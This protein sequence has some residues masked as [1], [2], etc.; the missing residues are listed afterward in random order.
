MYHV[1]QVAALVGGI[2]RTILVMRRAAQDG[3]GM[4]FLGLGFVS[5]ALGSW[6][7]RLDG[8]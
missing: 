1:F 4:T 6:R 2:A 5:G 3:H 8:G 7:P